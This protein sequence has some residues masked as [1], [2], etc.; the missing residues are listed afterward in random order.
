MIDRKELIEE[1]FLRDAIRKAI[2]A[3]KQKKLNENREEEILR[4]AIRR[5]LLSEKV[6]PL[7]SPDNP[8]PITAMNFVYSTLKNILGSVGQG[9]KSL[10]SSKQQ[11]DAFAAQLLD[12]IDNMLGVADE[13]PESIMNAMKEA[14]DLSIEDEEIPSLGALTPEEE[15][16]EDEKE[17]AVD[18]AIEANDEDVSSTL[19]GAGMDE[20][21]R[22]VANRVFKQIK[23]AIARD[24]RELDPDS[25]AKLPSG[26][27]ASERRVYHD[28]LLKIL[29]DHM[30]ET[31]EGQLSPESPIPETP[32]AEPPGGPT[33]IAEALDGDILDLSSL[34]L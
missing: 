18:A 3:V 7:G 33:N 2:I 20:T 30:L 11:R 34:N 19:D 28:F 5:T 9:Y 25:V 24:Y 31:F 26:Q 32:L 8:H 1:R 27:S 4:M 29:K 23:N 15:A 21:G 16:E 12:N 13:N 22:N 10:S 14:V 6:A 17:A